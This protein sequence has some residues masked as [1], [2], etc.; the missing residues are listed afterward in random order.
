[1]P[2]NYVSE[3][4]TKLQKNE[5]IT[6]L[7]IRSAS[8]LMIFGDTSG[9]TTYVYGVTGTGKTM[10][11]RNY[12]A[13]R[14]YYELDAA[15]I[16][17]EQLLFQPVSDKR[18]IV[19]IENLHELPFENQESITACIFDLMEREDIWLILISRSP[20]PPWLLEMRL[21]C[22]INVI[23]ESKL[24]FTREL[25][26]KYM[27]KTQMLFNDEQKEYLQDK[28]KGVPFIWAIA[29][30]EYR[31]RV[32][33]KPRI[34]E[35]QEFENYATEVELKCYQYLEY[36][37]YDQWEVDILEF[38]TELSIVDAFTEE[39]ANYI[40]GRHDVSELFDRIR[41]KGNFLNVSLTKDKKYL[42]AMHPAMI[43]SLNARLR[44]K[45]K[46]ERIRNL[47]VN[48]GMFYRIKGQPLKALQMFEAV[49]AK[50]R[51][52][53]LLEDNA[54]ISKKEGTVTRYPAMWQEAK[55]RQSQ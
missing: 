52:I 51:I 46:K 15:T 43:K 9:M 38:L 35:K 50:D 42:Y 39:M 10:M 40:T 49:D 45:Y 31:E 33:G 8:K 32:G 37:V 20:I 48:A 55:C 18:K 44:R 11:V 53:N 14:K 34:L 23:D 19:V 54:R 30:G 24:L 5:D 6:Y 26:E 1:M 36:H 13:R 41:W 3:N 28:I 25:A 12:L 17:E 7:R 21:R 16:T 2:E 29:A 4:E 27:E 22:E 47:Y